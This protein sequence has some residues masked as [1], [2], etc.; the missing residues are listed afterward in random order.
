MFWRYA[1]QGLAY[2]YGSAKR[3]KNSFLI[4]QFSFWRILLLLYD[5]KSLVKDTSPFILFDNVEFN[6][7]ISP[8]LQQK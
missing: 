1:L 4:Q 7:G 8:A 2:P 5:D 6:D 3:R